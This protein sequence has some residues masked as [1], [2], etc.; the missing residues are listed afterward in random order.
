MTGSTGFNRE[1]LAD[2]QRMGNTDFLSEI[3]KL[4]LDN[5]AEKLEAISTAS[6]STDLRELELHSHALKSSAANIGARQ[7]SEIAAKLEHAAMEGLT[8]QI[9]PIVTEL[10][11]AYKTAKILL[12]QE[13]EKLENE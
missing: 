6:D 13:L 4:F 11:S 7:L 2:L 12:E 9:V 5:A 8:D 1:R 3:I 10:Q